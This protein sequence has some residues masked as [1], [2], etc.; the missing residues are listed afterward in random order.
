MSFVIL[1]FLIAS[2]ATTS[3]N[4]TK[5]HQSV[6]PS[7]RNDNQDA[8]NPANSVPTQAN[9]LDLHQNQFANGRHVRLSTSRQL[10]D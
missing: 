3:S 5:V 2:E 7:V 9:Q 1:S 8:I 4:Y 6:R 10:L